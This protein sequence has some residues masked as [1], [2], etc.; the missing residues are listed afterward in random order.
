MMTINIMADSSMFSPS[1]KPSTMN[2]AVP[3]EN[4]VVTHTTYIPSKRTGAVAEKGAPA[5]D[6]LDKVDISSQGKAISN[7][8]EFR[9]ATQGLQQV[10]KINSPLDALK[11]AQNFVDA[12]NKQHEL[13]SDQGLNHE[14]L[15]SAIK[16]TQETVTTE[17][18]ER[19]GELGISVQPNGTLALDEN[20]LS[21]AFEQSRANVLVNFG[22]VGALANEGVRVQEQA[23]N[24]AAQTHTSDSQRITPNDINSAIPAEQQEQFAQQRQ[25]I[26]Q[27]QNMGKKPNNGIGMYQ[28]L[29]NLFG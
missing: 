27:L 7:L 20:K 1:A 24:K 23:L 19:L 8:D 17:S 16:Q 21:S 3:L 5:L 15:H 14:N 12:F 25:A 11:T 22:R 4:P 2:G 10:S 13:A 28:S 29:L 6:K 18:Q 26:E 9:L